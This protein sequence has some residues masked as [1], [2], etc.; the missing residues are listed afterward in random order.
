M[1]LGAFF[2]DYLRVSG[3]KV[4]CDSKNCAHPYTNLRD[5]CKKDTS[6]RC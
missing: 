5:L 4:A 1:E 2:G 6:L 3:K